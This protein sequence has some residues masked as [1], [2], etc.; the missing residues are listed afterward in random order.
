M[1]NWLRRQNSFTQLTAIGTAAS[2]VTGMVAVATLVITFMAAFMLGQR[3]YFGITY[4]PVL[5]EIGKA[6]GCLTGLSI[7][8]F[9]IFAAGL[10]ASLFVGSK[11][12]QEQTDD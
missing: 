6:A 4:P 9:L 12:G 11:A 7:L 8:G 10:I 5:D 1:Q 2:A 3:T